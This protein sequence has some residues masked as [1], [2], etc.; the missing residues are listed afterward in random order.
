MRKKAL[1]TGAEGFIGSHLVSHLVRQGWEVRA[2]VLY[3]SFQSIGWLANLSLEE[4]EE[5]EIFAGDIR[6]PQ[7]VEE[8]V[9]GVE[10][11][12]HLAALIA[13]PYSYRAASSYLEVNTRGTLNVLNAARKEPRSKTICVSTSEVYGTAQYVPIDEAHPLQPQSPYSASKI[14]AES[15]ARSYYH[16]FGLEVCVVRPF[17]TYGPRQSVRAVIPS[18]ILQ[19]LKNQEEIKLGDP[20]P[21][22]DFLFVHDH[23]AGLECIAN[24]DA[25]AGQ[26]LN[27]ATGQ[28]VSIGELAQFLIDKIKPNARIILDKKRLRPAGSEV[29]RLCGDSR[30]LHKITGWKPN[31][32]LEKGLE[33]TIAWFA[34]PDN[35]KFYAGDYAL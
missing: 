13:I 32:Q 14:A 26:V 1:V 6:D 19:L 20:N 31:Y 18:L 33:A 21:T 15:L 22:R 11:I 24:A 5:I 16:S 25:I 35:Q 27:M 12:F 7:L 10:V 28:E 8:A 3:N 4:Q 30:K 9:K 29:N 17:N 34:N 23:V 2:F